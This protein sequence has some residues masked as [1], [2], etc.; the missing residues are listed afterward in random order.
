MF[1]VFTDC[2]LQGLAGYL[3]TYTGIQG[4]Y[5]SLG[6]H[7][8]GIGL[9]SLRKTFLVWENLHLTGTEKIFT[10]PY[11]FSIVTTLRKERGPILGTKT[12]KFIQAEENVKTVLVTLWL[13]WFTLVLFL[14]KLE[15]AMAIEKF[16]GKICQCSETK[17]GIRQLEL[18]LI[19]PSSGPKTA[20]IKVGKDEDSDNQREMTYL[21]K[22]GISFYW[23]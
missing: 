1:K 2:H 13:L 7:F 17:K 9:R 22:T 20:W 23:Y 8:K 10:I 21:I 19:F 12:F 11:K 18:I 6:L 4:P 15:M 3:S 16:K 5:L 14:T